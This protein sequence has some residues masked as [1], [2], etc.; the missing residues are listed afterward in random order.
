M[1][2]NGAFVRVIRHPMETEMELTCR[3]FEKAAFALVVAAAAI[4]LAFVILEKCRAAGYEL[5]GDGWISD[6]LTEVCWL[7]EAVGCPVPG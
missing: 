3:A 1:G 4:L 6:R 7:T 5:F 2:S